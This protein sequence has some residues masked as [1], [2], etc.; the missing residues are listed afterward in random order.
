MACC[1]LCGMTSGIDWHHII[2]QA[3]GGQNGKQVPLCSG[4]HAQV[5]TDALA[6]YRGVMNPPPADILPEMVAQY[7]SLVSI[8]VLARRTY[9]AAR[10]SQAAPRKAMA[11]T[12]SG[13]TLDLIDRLKPV[14]GASSQSEVISLAV[15]DYAK[16]N[17]AGS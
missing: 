10:A 4:H 6:A 13:T 16:R 7:Q 11:V 3:Y 15:A 9:E 8:I 17:F 12:V 1:Q 2:P 5:H 14:C